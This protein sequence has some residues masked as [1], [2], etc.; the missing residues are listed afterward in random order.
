MIAIVDYNAGNLTSVKRALDALGIKSQIT[1]S[2][3]KIIKAERVIFPGVGNARSAME[4]LRKAKLIPALT[5]AAE[6]GTPF[7]GICLGM[8]MMTAHSDEG[9]TEG[10]NFFKSH[11]RLLPQSQG[12]KIP[13]M[14]WNNLKFNKKHKLFEGINKNAEFYFVHSYYVEASLKKD[15]AAFTEHGIQF[16]SVI[17]K[18]NLF[19]VQFHP[20]KSGEAGLRLLKNFTEW[21]GEQ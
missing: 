17:A 14:G 16:A 20:E 10:L 11:V 21:D 18:N 7:L 4:Q 9:D 19:A 5:K 8:Q 12:L 6:S 1:G 2:P 3:A 15:V 13:N